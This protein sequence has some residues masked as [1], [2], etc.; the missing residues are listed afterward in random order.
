MAVTSPETAL[1]ARV[2]AAL[3]TEFTSEGIKFRND[4]LHESL[5]RDGAIGG[6][7]PGPAAP[8]IG[9]VQVLDVVCY[10]Q[11]FGRWEAEVNPEQMVEPQPIEE[12]AERVRR[13][14]HADE[15][16][17]PADDHLWFYSVTRT[18]YPPDP[19]GNIS[20]AVFTVTAEAQNPALVTTTG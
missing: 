19:T 7:Y 11:L 15:G 20:R 3:E 10:V 9:Q 13:A 17:G 12:W 1:R 8:R 18:E 6:I 5:G 2:K 4:K 14:L 16:A